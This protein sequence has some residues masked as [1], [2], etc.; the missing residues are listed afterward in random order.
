MFDLV[1]FVKDGKLTR[2]KR[3]IEAL[4]GSVRHRN[5]PLSDLNIDK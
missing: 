1:P 2:W 4:E 5:R 3:Q